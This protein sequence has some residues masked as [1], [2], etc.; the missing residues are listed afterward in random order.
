ME[1]ERRS[2]KINMQDLAE[3]LH[4]FTHIGVNLE[5]IRE[6]RRKCMQEDDLVIGHKYYY[7]D[8]EESIKRS[9]R[10]SKAIQR[11][12]KTNNIQTNEQM[13]VYQSSYGLHALNL[14]FALALPALTLQSTPAQ[15]ENWLSKIQSM[16]IVACY[17]QTEL[18]HGSYVRGI[19]TEA[20]YD[21][22]TQQFTIN[23]PTPSSYKWWIGGAGLCANHAILIAQLKISGRSYGPHAFFIQIRD[24]ITHDPLSG[25]EIGD[26]GPKMGMDHMDNGYL[27]FL[28]FKVPKSSMLNRFSIIN[29]KGK[30]ELIDRNGIKILYLSLVS[31]RFGIIISSWFNLCSALTIS[32]RY[33]ITRTQFREPGH[34]SEKKLIDYQI[35]QYKLFIPLSFLYG[36]IFSRPFFCDLFEKAKSCIHERK[37]S[38]LQFTHTIMSLFKWFYSEHCAKYIEQVRASCGGHGFSKLSGLNTLYFAS[39]PVTTYEGDNHI[40]ALQ[41]IRYVVSLKDK[42]QPELFRFL[43]E[44]DG[45]SCLKFAENGFLLQWIEV[46]ARVKLAKLLACFNELMAKFGNRD[47]VWNDFLQVDGIDT[48]KW[49]AQALFCR[50]W[51]QVDCGLRCAVNRSAVAELRNLYFL[52]VLG[53]GVDELR[54][55]GAQGVELIS[56]E[57]NKCLAEVRKNALGLIEA[58]EIP[59]GVLNTAIGR[60]EGDP[61][62][63]LYEE[64]LKLNNLNKKN[65]SKTVKD[66][67]NP[68]L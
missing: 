43:F 52:D 40:L 50:I 68:K 67:I 4:R 30:Y 32:I 39:L 38:S 10:Y 25:V 37:A 61:Y 5:R 36:V 41:A 65:F 54:M 24:M 23:S 21:H 1:S 53:G 9:I 22:A 31:S 20:V 7:E 42:S 60:R 19:E 59:D 13:I 12:I 16:E 14:N 6:I 8:R 15:L 46:V 27:K 11:F 48:A 64:N 58:F 55:A 17:A 49:I 45:K 57:R 35:Q 56:V 47:K 28:N 63:L 34:K 51:S 2:G 62:K 26:I 33:S 18:G 3:E 44:N 29:E 66:L